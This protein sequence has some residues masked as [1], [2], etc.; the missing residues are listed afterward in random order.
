[1][2]RAHPYTDD[3][4]VDAVN[5]SRSWR[6]VLRELGLAGTSSRAI[7]GVRRRVDG[8]GISH[9]HFVGQRRWTDD[10]L[11]AAVA[12]ATSWSDVLDSLSLDGVAAAAAVR[13]HAARLGL[14]T[15]HLAAPLPGGEADNPQLD[16]VHLDRAGSLL[17]AAWFTL[18]GTV[19]SWPLE[20]SRYD[21]IVSA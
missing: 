7:R 12:A 3:E 19:V 8:L 5:A 21:L 17:A 11:S 6:G 10:Q 14:D 9:A 1:M 2:A 18:S 13:G 4:L 16:I 20:P 15:A